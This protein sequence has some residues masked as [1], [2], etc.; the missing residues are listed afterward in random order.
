[1]TSAPR[2]SPS[3]LTSSRIEI[4]A[5][6]FTS[7]WRSTRAKTALLAKIDEALVTMKKDGTLERHFDEVA[8]AC[9]CPEL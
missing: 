3:S 7:P 5:P 6:E 8:V 4:P 9:R 2:S 1:M